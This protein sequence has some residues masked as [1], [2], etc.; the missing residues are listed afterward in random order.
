MF[1]IFVI[2]AA[3]NEHSEG[4]LPSCKDMQAWFTIYPNSTFYFIDPAHDNESDEIVFESYTEQNLLFRVIV[5]IFELSKF[6][7]TYQIKNADT[8][9]FIDYASI[10]LSEYAYQKWFRTS[11]D[12]YVPGCYASKLVPLDALRI[13][14]AISRYSIN[15]NEPVSQYYMQ[16][17]YKHD[18]KNELFIYSMRARLLKQDKIPQWLLDMLPPD[19][20]VKQLYKEA[21]DILQYW[22]YINGYTLNNIPEA[23]WNEKIEK[24]MQI[25]EI[26]S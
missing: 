4:Q 17:N 6:H 14:K 26:I 18:V 8:C 5:G 15:S 13:A 2:G 23:R 20:P 24:I 9:L 25:P 3:S 19:V 16:S 11:W 7:S 22:F 10:E 21:K 1:H 12:Y